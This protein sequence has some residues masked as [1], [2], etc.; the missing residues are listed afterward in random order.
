[1]KTEV[2]RKIR[3]FLWK[4]E[5]NLVPG[6]EFKKY[7]AKC[8]YEVINCCR[9]GHLNRIWNYPDKEK[10]SCDSKLSG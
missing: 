5:D 2:K 10:K 4:D 9:L 6:S 8:L 7:V 3:N 1:M